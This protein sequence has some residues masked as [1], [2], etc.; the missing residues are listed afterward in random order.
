[1]TTYLQNKIQ[2]LFKQKTQ[3]GQNYDK[4]MKEYNG[5]NST[6]IKTVLLNLLK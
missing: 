5:Q 2:N 3:N 1:M 6:H 4:M